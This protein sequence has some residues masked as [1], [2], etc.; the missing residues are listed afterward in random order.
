M[1]D[2]S[3]WF[4]AEPVGEAHHTSRPQRAIMAGLFGAALGGLGGA[5]IGGSFAWPG[6][7]LGAA[8]WAVVQG[9]GEAATDWFR[10]PGDLKPGWWRI[11]A[12]AGPVALL[13][14]VLETLFGHGNLAIW[15]LIIGAGLG[16]FGFRVTKIALGALIG[17]LVGALF[18]AAWPD[19]HL[20]GVAAVIVIAY[21]SVAAAAYRGASQVEVMGER[22]DIGDLPFVV[23]FESHTRRVGADFL[24]EL[25]DDRGWDFSRQPA[26]VGILESLDSLDGPTFDAGLVDPVIREFYEHTSRFHLDIV[27]EWKTWMKPA[28]WVFKQLVSR[29]IDQINVPFN[30]REAQR[31]MRSFVDTV[32]IDHSGDVDIRA[33]IRTFEDSGDPIYVG[34]YTVLRGGGRGYVSVGFPLP[35]SNITVTLLPKNAPDGGLVLTTETSLPYPGHYL[36]AIERD[37]GDLTTL[38]LLLFSERIEVFLRNGDLFTDHR[39]SLGGI[40]FLTLHYS[41]VRA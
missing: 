27:P 19:V 37:G 17:G 22:V 18:N 1:S 34:I 13:G 23:P 2:R 24:R 3:Q 31:G 21:R 38:K 7:A 16:A 32:D 25:A 6:A 28:Y 41:M 30:Q 20:A 14:W 29:Q 10:E 11:I 33:W 26:D 5:A 36:S 4:A 9:S 12:A 35:S 15:G 39:F 40:T 8:I